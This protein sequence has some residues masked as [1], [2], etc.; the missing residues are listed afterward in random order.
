MAKRMKFSVI[1]LPHYTVWHLYEP[2]VDDLRHMEEMEQERKTREVEEKEK[3]A[4]L[5]KV[6]DEFTEP[7]AQWEKDKTELQ[8]MLKKEKDKGEKESLSGD[9]SG[10]NAPIPKKEMEAKQEQDS[11]KDKAESLSQGA[12]DDDDPVD[13][14]RKSAIVGQPKEKEVETESDSKKSSTR[15]KA[16]LESLEKVNAGAADADTDIASNELKSK[17]RS[18]EAASEAKRQIPQAY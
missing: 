2:S 14:K 10:P 13:R 17:L 8:D 11:R 18:K 3:Q 6:Q 9:E 5:K 12:V 7:T 1:G 16:V 15:A 4:R